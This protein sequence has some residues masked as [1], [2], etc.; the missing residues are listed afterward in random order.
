MSKAI[1]LMGFIPKVKGRRIDKVATTPMP[2]RSPIQKPI[3]VPRRSNPKAGQLRTE[4]R[5]PQN[6]SSM[7][8]LFPNCLYPIDQLR[9]YFQ[10][11]FN[12]CLDLLGLHW[13]DLQVQPLCLGEEI[14][15]IESVQETLTQELK[16]ILR[17]F[18]RGDI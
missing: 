14:W 16:I 2:G 5:L 10:S 17:C 8:T 15:I 12:N 1:A 7:A 11:T 4:R 3:K 6:V 9:G 13:A 18:G